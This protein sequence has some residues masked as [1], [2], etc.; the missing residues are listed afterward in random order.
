MQ[1]ISTVILSTGNQINNADEF[2]SSSVKVLEY[3][4]FQIASDLKAG[5]RLD[6]F[7]IYKIA[8]QSEIPRTR[9]YDHE[10]KTTE[11]AFEHALGRIFVHLH[12]LLG[13]SRIEPINSSSLENLSINPWWNPQSWL[14][15]VSA[16][17]PNIIPA[18]MSDQIIASCIKTLRVERSNT[19]TLANNSLELARLALAL[20]REAI[21]RECL[22]LAARHTLGYGWRKDTT[23]SEL[24][25]AIQFC[26]G[27]GVGNI[28]DWLR[29]VAPF[30]DDVFDFSEREIRHIPG[31]YVKL[32]AKHVPERIVDEFEYHMKQQNWGILPNILENFVVQ[33][34]LNSVADTFFLKCLASH[35]CIEAI[36][37]RSETDTRFTRLLEEQKMYFG[38]EP[39]A[40]RDESSTPTER[41]P[42][43]IEYSKFQPDNLN[44]LYIELKDELKVYDADEFINSWISYWNDAGCGVELV[45]AFERFWD[46]HTE[47]PY[48]M[49]R[50]LG[51]IFSLSHKLQG[52][53]KAYKW[54]VRD[55]RA[56]NHWARWSGRLAEESLNKYGRIYSAEWQT[57]LTDTTVGEQ[58]GVRENGWI[59]VPSCQLIS[60]L[61][62]AEQSDLA[63]QI[64]EI[65]VSSL[66]DEISHLPI[67]PLHW[68][69][70]PVPI[71]QISA[72]LLLLYY[73]WPDRYVRRRTSMQIA[74][75]LNN[76][77]DFRPLY[78][79]HLSAQKYETDISD[80]L[81]ILTLTD[82]NLFS[83]EE[84]STAIKFPSILS[85]QILRE[86]GY[87]SQNESTSKYFSALTAADY[88]DSSLITRSRDGIAPVYFSTINGLG[89]KL[90]YPLEKHLTA[91]WNLI[92]ARQPFLFFSPYDFSGD[93][94][95]RQ[96]P[97]ACSFSTNAETLLTSASLR[98]L[99]FASDAY[100]L[101][102][103]Q[104]A[105]YAANL[106]PFSNLLGKLLPASKPK[107]WPKFDTFEKNEALPSKEDL[108]DMLYRLSS[109]DMVILCANGP[110]SREISGVNC[111]LSIYT[112]FVENEYFDDPKRLYLSASGAI[113]SDE[114]SV[115][116]LAT[117][118]FPNYLG[119]FEI[120]FLLRG[121][122]QPEFSIG[123][124]SRTIISE[125]D[126]LS[127]ISDDKC[128]AKWKYW[129]DSWYP[130]FPKDIGP[131]LGT[132][133]ETPRKVFDQ[134]TQ[135]LDGS[136]YMVANLTIL[137]K[138][139]YLREGNKTE[140]YALR[141]L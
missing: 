55:I 18:T 65:M 86:L 73:K 45:S 88:S 61:L 139:D 3:A 48:L 68:Q 42:I 34:D 31:W 79:E 124:G 30:V 58:I 102:T 96:D 62:E 117:N 138:R 89:R 131:A 23:F 67:S 109:T 108:D 43:E 24:F 2:F 56:N 72:R 125:N 60:Y 103:E 20:K 95:Y 119:R 133:L 90:N 51:R 7:E 83:G 106:L 21:G 141:L 15:F 4:A 77:M 64:T 9:S 32:L 12:I 94:F 17:T 35:E 26:S 129:A 78:L 137:D 140:I 118:A 57:L 28:A 52:A 128:C 114:I 40:P 92:S 134:L 80:L 76:D 69:K 70:V 41:K 107:N 5:I 110:V 6:S 25:D 115:Y 37:K 47:F 126:S 135:D 93:Y 50:A 132:Y 33:S 8:L 75:L 59:I 101:S 13:E 49:R 82:Q 98:T 122:F 120:D 22:V 74:E 104:I 112:V 136:S 63:C 11:F 46:R 99:A 91:E 123:N 19:S 116:P 87:K 105:L 54:A 130:V 111:D 29:R 97:I 1:K 10:L 38:G 113:K 84:L 81:S 66:E 36:A 27:H 100:E 127:Y 39:M 14:K 71:E 85:R 53:R 44:E 121:L 16:W